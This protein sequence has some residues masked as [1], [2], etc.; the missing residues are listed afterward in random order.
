M[1]TTAPT[2]ESKVRAIVADQLGVPAAEIENMARLVEDLGA[3]VLDFYELV[4][5]MEETF[6]VDI[7]DGD[8]RQIRTVQKAVAYIHARTRLTLQAVHAATDS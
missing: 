3:D 7:P 8:A 6:E 2:I 1:T 4:T 5:A